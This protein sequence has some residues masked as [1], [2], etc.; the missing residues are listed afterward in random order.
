MFKRGTPM[1]A[2]AVNFRER[3]EAGGGPR[4]VPRCLVKRGVSFVI[5][6]KITQCQ[7]EMIKRFA[8]LRIGVSPRE[9]GDGLAEKFFSGGKFTA[10]QMPKP[11]R[12]VAARIERV[13]AQRFTPIRRWR[14]EERRVGKECRSRWSPDH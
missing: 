1:V 4:L 2:T 12:V 6:A 14:S 10:A 13:A 11:H 3:V 8:V 9:A 7:A 5:A